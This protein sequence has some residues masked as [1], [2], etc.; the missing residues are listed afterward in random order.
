MEGHTLVTTELDSSRKRI[1]REAC[2]DHMLI[3]G[4]NHLY[5]LI[6]KSVSFFNQARPHQGITQ[7][8]PEKIKSDGEEEQKGRIIAF[9]VLNGLHYDY[10]R[11]A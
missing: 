6:K 7:K 9:P 11:A 4:E 1:G 8:I 2:L 5:H 3:L 10:Q